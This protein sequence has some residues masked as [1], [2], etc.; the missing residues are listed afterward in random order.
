MVIKNMLLATEE[1]LGSG[2]T[3]I[4]PV[5]IFRVKEGVNYNPEDPNYDLFKLAMHCSAK[6]LF[7]NFSFL[8]A[9]FNAQYYK[10]TPETEIAYMGCRTRVMATCTIPIARSRPA[11]ATCPSPPSTCPVWPS[12]PRAMSTCSSTCSIPSCS[13]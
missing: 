12:A 5:Q 8:D 9:P 10:G 2:E 1:G 4:F 11:A 6:R 3:P 13:W 7:P